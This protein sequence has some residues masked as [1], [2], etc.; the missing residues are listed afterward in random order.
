M[1]K[2]WQEILEYARF[3]PS[4]HNIQ[5]WKVKIISDTKAELYYLPDRLLP[6][7]DPTGRFTILG[8]GIFIE[9]INIAAH[10]YGYKVVEEYPNTTFDY[11]QTRPTYFAT[12]TLESTNEEEYL[13][14]ELIKSRRTS[15]IQYNGQTID[16]RPLEELKQIATEYS[17]ELT[18]T[19][20]PSLVR[21]LM[22]LNRDTLFYDMNDDNSRTEVGSWTRASMKEALAKKDGLAAY[23]LGFPG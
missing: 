14:P 4:P 17:N 16:P 13:N 20:D 5:P 15:R 19:T 3:A 21:W 8:F 12:I 22:H 6:K 1:L 2:H 7:T 18:I 10:K 11:T 23:A 9:T